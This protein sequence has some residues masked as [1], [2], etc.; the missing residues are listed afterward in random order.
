[1]SKETEL[2]ILKLLEH[3]GD[4]SIPK[5]SEL[6]KFSELECIST[7]ATLVSQGYVHTIDESFSLSFY[8]KERLRNEPKRE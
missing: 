1:L 7:I 6:L 5:I 4:L 3:Y 8:G 2:A